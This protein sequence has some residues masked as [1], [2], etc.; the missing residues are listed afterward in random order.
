[1]RTVLCLA[2]LLLVPALMHAGLRE[3]NWVLLKRS[4][5]ARFPEVQWITTNELAAWLADE[6]RRPPALLDVRTADEWAVSHLPGAR[7]ID[8]ASEPEALLR[9]VAKDQPIV[10]YCAI[11]YRSADMAIKLKKAGFGDVRNLEGSIFQWANEHRPLVQDGRRV[12]TIHPYDGLWAHFVLPEARA[13]FPPQRP[14]PSH[15]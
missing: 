5:R 3:A 1:M 15:N 2:A 8:P 6:R 7:R 11:G 14:P 12:T 9:H 10:T 4:L 13:A